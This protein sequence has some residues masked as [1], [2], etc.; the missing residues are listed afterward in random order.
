MWW[1]K[2]WERELRYSDN[3]EGCVWVSVCRV[4]DGNRIG[5]FRVPPGLCIITGLSS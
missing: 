4:V 2:C 1:L 3:E 5:H